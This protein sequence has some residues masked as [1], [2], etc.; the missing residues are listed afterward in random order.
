[1]SEKKFNELIEEL[2]KNVGL[3]N[4][5]A[6]ADNYCCLGFDEKIITHIQYNAENDL[7]MLFSQLGTVKEEKA[8]D[9]YPR[10]LKANLFWQGTG[11]A[12]IGVDDETR[13]I[14]LAYQVAMGDM[15]YQKFQDLMESFVNTSELWLNTLDLYQK[16]EEKL[17]KKIS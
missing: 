5:E 14:L 11:G 8:A 10:L 6:D 4:L 17:E 7:I 1:M 9:L 2:G 13:E 12:T 16:D 3:S 15:D